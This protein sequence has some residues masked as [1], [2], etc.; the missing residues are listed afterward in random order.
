MYA[1]VK[2]VESGLEGT[3]E[4]VGGGGV[5][6]KPVFV[7]KEAVDFIGEDE[8]F[9]MDVAGAES[10]GERGSLSVGDVR[11]VVAMNEKHGRAPAVDGG[12]W[13]AGVGASGWGG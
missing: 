7:Q 13:R 10:V 2:V 4:E 6:G 3:G 11:V 1:K 12:H 9:D 5:G 8:L